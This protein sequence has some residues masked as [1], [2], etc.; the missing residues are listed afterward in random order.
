MFLWL[1]NLSLSLVIASPLPQGRLYLFAGDQVI[2]T[3]PLEELY[4]KLKGQWQWVEKGKPSLKANQVRQAL[5]SAESHG[6]VSDLYWT[7]LHEKLYQDLNPSREKTFEILVSDAVIRYAQD[8]SRGQIIEPDLIDEDIKL[9]KKNLNLIQD[10][11]E[12]LKS[13]TDL[14]SLLESFAPQNRHYQNLKTVLKQLISMKNKN[15]WGELVLPQGE[16]KPGTSHP[17]LLEVKKRLQDLG[18]GQLNSNATYD[19]AL[20]S[21]ARKFQ[22]MNSLSTRRNLNAPFF[23]ALKPSLESRI[24][25]VKANLEKIRWFPRNWEGRHLFVNL[26]FQEAEVRDGNSTILKMKTVNGRPTR[27]TPTL[28]DEI[29]FVEPSPTWTV[30]FSIAVKDKLDLLK[31]DPQL[32]VN[33]Q[34][35]VY[36]QNRQILDPF[37]ID[38]NQ[39]DR[40]NF[41]Y[42]LIQQPGPHNALGLIKFPLTNPWFIYMHDTNEP[43]LMKESYRLRSSGCVRMEKPWELASYLLSDQPEWTQSKLLQKR[44][45]TQQIFLKQKLPVYFLYLTVQLEPTGEIRFAEDYYGQDQRLLELFDTRGSLEKF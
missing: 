30:P 13:S 21:A 39:I 22:Q 28:R 23:N 43:H 4:T 18:Y 20:E 36:D 10:L 3:A 32:L 15:S 17:S 45:S 42:V 19:A 12:A 26:A 31:K 14:M 44:Y 1:L 5:L 35:L 37:Q 8:L 2:E 29:R 24:L 6:L 33:Q 16:I 7:A 25:K 9:S 34:I 27:R 41:K 11:A 38:W 40:T